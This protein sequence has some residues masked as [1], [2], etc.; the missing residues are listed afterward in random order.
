MRF[1]VCKIDNQEIFAGLFE[2]EYKD[3]S[4]KEIK[5]IF[6]TNKEILKECEFFDV[7]IP[8]S[9]ILFFSK[10]YPPV[11][12]E[13]IEKIVKQDIESETVFNSKDLIIDFISVE[14][15]TFVF[16]VKKTD[17]TNTISTLGEEYKDKIRTIIPE[18]ALLFEENKPTQTIFIGEKESVFFDKDGQII[19]KKGFL[20]IKNSLIEIFGKSQ[21]DELFMDWF[22]SLENITSSDSGDSRTV[23]KILFK[24]FKETIEYFEKFQTPTE[25]LKIAIGFQLPKNA[26]NL[27]SEATEFKNNIEIITLKT[28]TEKAVEAFEQNKTIDFAKEE[29]SYKG[30]FK[31]LKQRI[32]MIFILFIFS[33]L[34]MFTSMEIRISN[35][36]TLSDN[37]DKKSNKIIKSTLGKTYPSMKQALSIM[38]KTIKGGLVKDKKKLFPYS[39][40]YISEQIFP[41]IAFKGSTIEI[42]ALTIKSDGKIRIAGFSDTLDDINKMIE[43]LQ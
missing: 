6:S 1:A 22:L 29:F 5:Q 3:Y 40:L 20:N 25:K 37:L 10:I 38:I 8:A 7:I 11:K 27:I 23:G 35:L 18:N 12:K 2:K 4:F 43:N 24:F 14:E 21:N 41:S 30:G 19:T 17:L 42:K 36:D 9:K 13:Q 15:K 39:S 33:F 28:I 26:E 16:A 31:F 34:I 32:L